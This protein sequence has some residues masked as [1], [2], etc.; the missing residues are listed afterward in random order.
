MNVRFTGRLATVFYLAGL[1][2]PPVCYVSRCDTTRCSAV[3]SEEESCCAAENA[4]GCEKRTAPAAECS[5]ADALPSVH[6]SIRCHCESSVATTPATAVVELKTVAEAGDAVSFGMQ[7][8]SGISLHEERNP[9]SSV[10]L[11]IASTVLRC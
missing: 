10:H 5:R 9:L 1:L 6:D 2:T 11:S 4:A 3:T 8:P 7:S